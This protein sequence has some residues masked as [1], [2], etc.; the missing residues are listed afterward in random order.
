MERWT[1]ELEKEEKS[2]RLSKGLRMQI[3]G[4]GEDARTTK[5]GG[6]TVK[7]S[8]DAETLAGALGPE[9]DLRGSGS[10]GAGNTGALSVGGSGA[11]M[12]SIKSSGPAEPAARGSNS[13]TGELLV[14]NKCEVLP[15]GSS[16]N[17]GYSISESECPANCD[18]GQIDNRGYDH[19]GGGMD[20][21]TTGKKPMSKAGTK[22]INR[23][24]DHPGGVMDIDTTVDPN[25]DREMDIEGTASSSKADSSPRYRTRS[26]S[27]PMDTEETTS[28]IIT[29]E[30]SPVAGLSS[31]LD[32]PPSRYGTRSSSRL[33]KA[34]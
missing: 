15:T 17:P 20:I 8:T 34:R 16:D 3:D 7:S 5:V 23:G 10:Q 32:N 11:S 30:F 28:N 24:F 14:R 27:R 6:S 22:P 19:P 9:S 12:S 13:G 2:V 1:E 25:R 4:E 26:R 33:K 31:A 18:G 21:D 29:A